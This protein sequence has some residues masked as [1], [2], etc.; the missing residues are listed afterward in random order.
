MSSLPPIWGFQKTLGGLRFSFGFPLSKPEKRHQLQNSPF[1]KIWIKTRV[2]PILNADMES[3]R[4]SRRLGKPGLIFFG[5]STMGIGLYLILATI[6]SGTKNM[7]LDSL[8]A[9][10]K[11]CCQIDQ[12]G[13]QFS[14]PSRGSSSLRLSFTHGLKPALSF[15]AQ[16][17]PF[18]SWSIAVG[19]FRTG[20]SAAVASTAQRTG[21]RP[22]VSSA[23]GGWLVFGSFAWDTRIQ[24]QVLGGIKARL[25]N[26]THL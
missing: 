22:L 11:E 12:K 5:G 26:V 19:W 17:L 16:F 6:F 13:L 23:S 14:E 9:L 15:P 3:D 2:P 10:F 4:E 21:R 8:I 25:K 24:V 7:H 1:P 18:G 20:C